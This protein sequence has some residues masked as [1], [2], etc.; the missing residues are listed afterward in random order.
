M[1]L[2]LTLSLIFHVCVAAPTSDSADIL[3][4]PTVTINHPKATIIGL[5]GTATQLAVEQFPG[6]PFAK[7]PVGPLRLKPPQPLTKPQGTIL[8]L[9]NGKACPQMIF[10]TVLND[11]IPTSEI[12]LLL[13]TPLFQKTL[14]EGEDC[15]VLNVHRPAGTT[16][17]DR[18]PVLFWIFGGGFELGW[19]SMYDGS[20]WVDQSMKQGQPIIVVTVN[21]RVGGFGFLAGKEILADG[22]SNL[23]LLDR[24]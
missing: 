24:K 12:G 10:S 3:G 20:I 23:G 7:P 15:L 9:Q 2:I 1:N 5:P 21:Y 18:L 16:S 4:I 17:R 11:A 19:N 8:A 22:S 13:N 6:I 14:N